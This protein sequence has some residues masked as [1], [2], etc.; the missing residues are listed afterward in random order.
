M[1]GFER[2]FKEL[3]GRYD[4]PVLS[5]LEIISNIGKNMLERSPVTIEISAAS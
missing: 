2:C 4:N 3:R 5:E 1:R